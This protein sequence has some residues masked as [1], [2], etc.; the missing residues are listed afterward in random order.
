MG[1][2][3]DM[4]SRPRAATPVPYTASEGLGSAL[5]GSG[6]MPQTQHLQAMGQVGTLFAIV[7]R[8]AQ[9]TGAVDWHLHR[10]RASGVCDE[11]GQRGVVLKEDHQAVRLW[12]RPN[13]FYDRG[14]LVETVQQ[15]VDLVGEGWMVV[16]RDERFPTVPVELWPVRPDRMGIYEHPS[17]Y[18]TGYF[19]RAPNGE[20]VPLGRDE[21]IRLRMPSPVDA[22]R[23][24]GPVQTM[25]YDLD[26]ARYS[27]AWNR[28]FFVNNA[29]PGGVIKVQKA[30]TDAEFRQMRQ[31]WNEQHRGVSRAHRVGIL[32]NADWVP[33]AFNQRDMQFVELRN[34]QR[35]LLREAFGIPKFALGIVEDVNRASA[36]ASRAW[37]G[38]ELT[39]PRLERY[40]SALNNRLLLIF[41]QAEA[42]DLSFAYSSPVPPDREAERAERKS[43]AESYKLL[44]EANVDPA[45]AANVVGYPPLRLS[46]TS[47]ETAPAL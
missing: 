5:S 40:R 42:R 34:V 30:L 24:M 2:L 38:A 15:H 6:G 37:F 35:D 13:D 23:G 20:E 16:V 27:A 18:L 31:R 12:R 28:N 43:K 41:G 46:N 19:Y 47:N 1:A 26:S 21:V 8:L 11:C 32:E 45:D 36:D 7:S 39:V 33:R 22:Y 25:L 14:L 4:V 9:S 17:E 44:I 3:A 10:R 29:E